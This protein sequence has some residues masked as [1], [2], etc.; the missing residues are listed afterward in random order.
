MDNAGTDG[1]Y[2]GWDQRTM[3][4]STRSTNVDLTL[5]TWSQLYKDGGAG[6]ESARQLQHS[7]RR[8]NGQCT[9]VDSSRHAQAAIWQDQT[10]VK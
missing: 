6:D 5:N 1:H 3:D 8:H 10:L 4:S 7:Q 9:T 2:S